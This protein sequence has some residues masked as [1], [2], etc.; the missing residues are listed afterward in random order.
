MMKIW[1]IIL[2]LFATPLFAQDV[3]QDDLVRL[4]GES[5]LAQFK[6]ELADTPES[7]AQGLM[8]REYMPRYNG[9]LFIFEQPKTASFWMR[10]TLI[11]LDILF[12]DR[13]GVLTHIHRNAI[14]LDET[15]IPGGDNVQY[16]LEINA[17]LSDRLGIKEGFALQHPTIDGA[18]AAWACPQ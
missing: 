12:F 4:R 13:A 8:H 11:P 16:V 10:N 3:C 5:V 1:L 14:P 15:P 9:M 6:V 2:A 17:G 7:Q 18:F